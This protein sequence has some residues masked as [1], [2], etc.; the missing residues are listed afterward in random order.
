MT[1][2]AEM[3]QPAQRRC[4]L[5]NVLRE[6]FLEGDPSPEIAEYLQQLQD[7]TGVAPADF[8]A[9][10]QVFRRLGNTDLFREPAGQK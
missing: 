2:L 9:D 4:V 5:A 6:A 3:L 1:A 8:G 7:G 10:T